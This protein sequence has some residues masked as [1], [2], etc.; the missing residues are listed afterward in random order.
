MINKEEGE[1]KTNNNSTSL[2]LEHNTIRLSSSL[3]NTPQYP[4]W[5]FPSSP[6][7]HIFSS[8]AQKVGRR[9]QTKN[10]NNKR[11]TTTGHII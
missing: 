8:I 7:R 3:Y 9:G 10:N 1:K 4:P 6:C 11:K 2:M 5:A